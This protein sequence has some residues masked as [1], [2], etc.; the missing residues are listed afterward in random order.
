MASE[1]DKS[2][3]L[4]I[5]LKLEVDGGF[6]AKFVEGDDDFRANLLAP[7]KFDDDNIATALARMDSAALQGYLN[8]GTVTI[9]GWIRVP[10]G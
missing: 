4:E 9:K 8:P 7:W 2:K 10:A 3:L 6:L 5:L 1:S